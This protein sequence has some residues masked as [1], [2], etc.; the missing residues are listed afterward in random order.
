LLDSLIQ[1][2]APLSVFGA[3]PDF[4]A[5]QPQA[6]YARMNTSWKLIQGMAH[7]DF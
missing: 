3:L 5:L 4:P 2:V 1:R 7:K 6:E